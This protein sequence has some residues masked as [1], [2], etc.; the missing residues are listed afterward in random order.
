MIQINTLKGYE[1]VLDIYFIDEKGNV[2]SE[3]KKGYLFQHDNG[4]GYKVVSLKIKGI[5]KWKKAYVHRLV[6]MAF[7]P[8]P[9]N[10]PEVNHKDENKEN[11]DVCNLEWISRIDNVN[12]G[13]GTERQVLKRTETIF[14]YDYLLNF[15]GEF[16]GMNQATIQTLG[17]SQTRGL[18]RRVKNYYFLSEP[19]KIEQIIKINKE[20]GY[21]TVVVENVHTGEKKYFP[22]NRRAREFFENKVNVTDAIKYNWLVREKFKIYPLDYSE[23]KDSPILR[24]KQP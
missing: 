11:N 10:L 23:L 18:N 21:Q 22:N 2:Y 4:R 8:N 7:I 3:S 1:N 20:S 16:R 24:E 14:V 19:L 13:T 17:Y 9:T 15:V 5:R 12:Y 6:A